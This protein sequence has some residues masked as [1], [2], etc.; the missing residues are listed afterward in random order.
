MGDRFVSALSIKR[1]TSPVSSSAPSTFSAITSSVTA[2][3]S[4][5]QS[6]VA[7]SVEDNED[8]SQVR[9]SLP[10]VLNGNLYIGVPLY[11]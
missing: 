11:L 4:V 6:E 8:P 3:S 9:C 1:A 5:K 7:S 10:F 2:A